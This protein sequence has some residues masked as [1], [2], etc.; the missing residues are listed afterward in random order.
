MYKNVC[1]AAVAAIVLIGASY[2]VS[3]PS[4]ARSYSDPSASPRINAFAL[5]AAVKDLPSEQYDTH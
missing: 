5:T 2:L 1:F 4:T 3:A